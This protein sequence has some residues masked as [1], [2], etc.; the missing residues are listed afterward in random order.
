VAP[1]DLGHGERLW[2]SH[3]ELLDRFDVDVVPSPR[4]GVT[5]L[6]LWR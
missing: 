5:H 3:E 1:L 2:V 4:S 6:L